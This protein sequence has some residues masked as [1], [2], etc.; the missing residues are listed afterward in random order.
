[1][2]CV[3]KDISILVVEDDPDTRELLKV[4]LQSQGADR[5]AWRCEK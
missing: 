5:A 4:L 1:M 3:L 2:D